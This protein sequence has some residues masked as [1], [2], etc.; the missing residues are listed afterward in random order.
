[1]TALTVAARRVIQ[2][3]AHHLSRTEPIA[4]CTQCRLHRVDVVTFDGQPTAG[5]LTRCT[6]WCQVCFDHDAD[7]DGLWV[8]ALP[9][10]AY[11]WAVQSLE[12]VVTGMVERGRYA[13][14]EVAS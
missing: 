9:G 1:M 6:P 8:T 4:K 11:G 5:V 2:Q 14:P 10:T 7:K 12:V 13:G 3:A